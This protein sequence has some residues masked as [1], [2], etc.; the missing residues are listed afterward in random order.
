MTTLHAELDR[1][2]GTCTREWEATAL[3]P[4]EVRVAGVS[5]VPQAMKAKQL[6]ALLVL[7]RGR[8]VRMSTIE[9]ELWEFDPPRNSATA[10]Q[11]CVMQI[12]K[13][14]DTA[15][16]AGQGA[17]A[18]KR[19]LRTE[20]MGYLLQVPADEHVDLRRYEDRIARARADEAAGDLVHASTELQAALDTWHDDPLADVTPGPSL[21]SELLRLRES[22]RY[23]H[24]RRIGLDLRLH[25]YLELI[26][27]LRALIMLDSGE[28]GYDEALRTYLMFALY[29]AGRRNEALAV[30]RDLRRQLS[31]EIGLEPTRAARDLHQK[32]MVDAADDPVCLADVNLGR[33]SDCATIPNQ[34]REPA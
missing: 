5:I 15:L 2:A 34:R 8:T 9:R 28:N 7:N 21:R 30:Y 10:I 25:R 4:L 23:V 18:A 6:L 12:R 16:D 31:D 11:N 1:D 24:K 27:E 17:A 19:I 32:I 3:G 14:L 26:G 33:C 20:P 22:R 13:K 29:Q